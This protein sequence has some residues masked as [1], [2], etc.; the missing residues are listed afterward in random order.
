MKLLIRIVLGLLVL[1]AV[2]IAAIILIPSKRTPAQAQAQADSDISVE[3]GKYVMYAGDCMA[4]HTAPDGPAFAGGRAIDSPLGT[5]WSTNITPDKE[6][7]I[8]NYTLDDF[9]ASMYD[10]LRKDGVHLYPAMP[11]ENFRVMSEADIQSLY[12]Y[13]MQQVPAVR[14][15]VP[16]TALAFPFNQRWGL[17][18]WNW[19]ALGPVGFTAPGDDQQINRGAYLVQGAGHC[20]ACH[21]PRTPW[22]SQK[23]LTEKDSAFLSGGE[24]DG[25]SV[26]ALSGAHSAISQWSQNELA[27]YMATGRNHAATSVGEMA[28][29]VENSLQYLDYKDNQAIAAYL[30]SLKQAQAGPNRSKEG[31]EITAT[32]SMLT[33]ADPSMPLG[34][35]L[36]M[37]NCLGCHMADGRG[38]P[39]IFPELDGNALVTAKQAKGLIHV[40]LH[41]AELPSTERRPA[42]LRMQAYGWRLDDQEVAELASFVRQA[43][44]NKAG[45]V[46]AQEVQAVR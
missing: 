42:R 17:R 27:D 2:V 14:N 41:G 28:L 13:F 44:H 7:G 31:T 4:C 15:A 25:W 8:G 21:S 32:E 9:R 1:A 39:E 29:V 23:G 40:I 6:T 24:L 16:E 34:A 43:W 37:D 19:L 18:A 5:I 33:S 20:A 46:S 10:G 30:L 26:P 38:A 45:N 3:R 35:R 11:Y 12:Q 22:M 36:Y